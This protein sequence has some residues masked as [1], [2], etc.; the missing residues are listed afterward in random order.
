MEQ[1]GLA[2]SFGP[3]IAPQNHLPDSSDR[4]E[5]FDVLGPTSWPVESCFPMGVKVSS[6]T[7]GTLL[8][9]RHT[10]CIV[11]NAFFLGIMQIASVYGTCIQWC[12]YEVARIWK[13]KVP[14][15]IWRNLFYLTFLL[16]TLCAVSSPKFHLL[17]KAPWEDHL[18]HPLALELCRSSK[19][20]FIFIFIFFIYFFFFTFLEGSNW[21]IRG[22]CLRYCR[23]LA[24]PMKGDFLR[25]PILYWGSEFT[26]GQP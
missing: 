19:V 24:R 2:K 15:E 5:D 14:L 22:S 9:L 1:A 26:L 17:H 7:H 4:E 16:W 18:S 8:A 10:R 21:D 25:V 3:I 6:S 11:V 13:L 20:F 12:L 23:Q